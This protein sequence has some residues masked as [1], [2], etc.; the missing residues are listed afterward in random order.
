MTEV[1]IIPRAVAGRRQSEIALP[2]YE[3][4]PEKKN[5]TNKTDPRLTGPMDYNTSNLYEAQ[6]QS[7]RIPFNHQGVPNIQNFVGRDDD[8]TAME[9]Y[10]REMPI[11]QRILVLWA[12][13]GFGKTQLAVAFANKWHEDFTSTFFLQGENSETLNKS[14]S[15]AFDQI[16]EKWAPEL[17]RPNEKPG[18]TEEINKLFLRWLS[19]QQNQRWLLIVDSVDGNDVKDFLPKGNHGS[20]I[21]TTRRREDFLEMPNTKIQEI[22]EMNYEDSSK[23]L[24]QTENL[25]QKVDSSEPIPVKI[26]K[27]ADR[28]S[29]LQWLDGCPIAIYSV[30]TKVRNSNISYEELLKRY[31]YNSSSTKLLSEKQ[32]TIFHDDLSQLLASKEE[33]HQHAARLLLL[34]SY[35]DPRSIWYSL[36]RK[37]Q[38]DPNIPDWFQNTVK[39]E[40]D[41]ES[42]MEVLLSYALIRVDRNQNQVYSFH[43]VVREACQRFAEKQEKMN[44]Y[45]RLAVICLAYSY[46]DEFHLKA[47]EIKRRLS[48][49]GDAVVQPLLDHLASGRVEFKGFRFQTLTEEK[50]TLIM[51]LA[52]ED[53]DDKSDHTFFYSHPL[54]A[55]IELLLWTQRHTEAVKISQ[56]GWKTAATAD[57]RSI[58][59]TLY[60]WTLYRNKQLE[61][62]LA[63][64]LE[65][66]KLTV[67]QFGM[68]SKEGL[69]TARLVAAVK[70]ALNPKDEEA[71]RFGEEIIVICRRFCSTESEY[72]D[73]VLTDQAEAY[74]QCG[75]VLKAQNLY[76]EAYHITRNK[77][78]PKHSTTM[79][80]A[81]K[82]PFCNITTEV[83][84][85][86]VLEGY[87]YQLYYPINPTFTQRN[88][89]T[90]V[91]VSST[92]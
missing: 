63:P 31:K 12:A 81:G 84:H 68:E 9:E 4:L 79:W 32:L 85:F 11:R 39:T 36:L 2:Q 35:L 45:L 44:D 18:K 21:V 62:A 64:S 3:E 40:G 17:G 90:F 49:H 50:R 70:L 86:V 20:I 92:H 51:E 76:V 43:N 7:F 29:L 6:K 41:F 19:I 75:D 14:I 67:E 10:L 77:L 53:E 56:A 22:K 48:P 23:L 88:A 55:L 54:R 52:Q 42:A 59:T 26:E 27:D 89:S 71:V 16:W 34:C 47:T 73:G 91:V 5:L 87:E 74:L 8:L 57:D 83:K 30:G 80:K 15:D 82:K 69:F 13:P 28:K 60:G 1:I 66:H 61:E 58:L 46:P 24:Y 72:Y 25:F 37:G 38:L 78:G 65:A 33:S